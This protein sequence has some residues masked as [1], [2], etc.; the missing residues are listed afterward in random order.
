MKYLVLGV[1]LLFNFASAKIY[2]NSGFGS[3]NPSEKAKNVN[4]DLQS[5]IDLIPRATIEDIVKKW[6]T[7]DEEV[8]KDWEW[9][10][11]DHTHMLIKALETSP[12]FL[13]VS[14][15]FCVGY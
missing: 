12:E 14:I 11:S 15:F 5:L 7:S 13:A 4:D 1:M 9:G 6:V 2:L 10:T 3:F 8:K